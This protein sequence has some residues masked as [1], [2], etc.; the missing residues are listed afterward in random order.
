MKKLKL[1]SF[2]LLLALYSYAQGISGGVKA[3]LNFS[4]QNVDWDGSNIDTEV[5]VGIHLGGYMVVTLNEKF[6][7]QP[8]ILFSMQGAKFPDYDGKTNF[9][10]LNVPILARYQINEMFSVHAGPQIGFLLTANTEEDGD[11]FDQKDDFDGIDI[12]GAIGVGAEW[13]SGLSCGARYVL[14]FSQISQ[15]VEDIGEFK[16]RVFQLYAAYKLFDKKEQ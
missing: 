4:N 11:K 6:G 10:Y 8:E 1:T 16:N 5:K 14:G 3:G 12:G 9:N 13:P 2:I 15:D 7:I